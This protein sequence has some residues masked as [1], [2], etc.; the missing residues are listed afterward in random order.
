MYKVILSAFA[1]SL[2]MYG[3]TLVAQTQS[4]DDFLELESEIL[5]ELKGEQAFTTSDLHDS[6]DLK[7]LP[8]QALM[9]TP[10]PT[11]GQKYSLIHWSD[12]DPIEWMDIHTWV[13]ERQI[14]DKIPNWK[15]S[16]RLDAHKELA[17]KVLKCHGECLSYRGR[18]VTRV[19]HL[20]RLLEGD[21]IQTGT[22][23]VAWIF[24]M[25]GSLVR[26][27][28]HTSISIHEINITSNEFF[29]LIRLNHG[30]IYW[31]P[32]TKNEIPTEY[33]PETDAISLPILVRE[34]NQEHFE[35]LRRQTQSDSEQLLETMDLD[36]KAIDDQFAKISAFK[37]R[38]NEKLNLKSKVMV[39]ASNMTLI[40]DN[41]SFDILHTPGGKSFF[42]KRSSEE[43]HELALYLRGYSN[44]EK[45]PIPDLDWNE[46]DATGRVS[47][48]VENLPGILQIIELISKRIKTIE[49]AREH[50]VEE[51]TLPL[52]Q[53]IKNPEMLSKD[54][55]YHL[56]G[57]EHIKRLEF[58][59][60]Y[61]RRQ[62]T[63][64]LKA[65]DNLV[66]KFKKNG[67][68]VNLEISPRSYQESLNHYLLGLK[69][70][71]DNKKIQVRDMN[72]LQYYVWILKNGKF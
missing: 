12:L 2:M 60:E 23:S 69:S 43:G 68:L 52:V 72:D 56:W 7:V 47:N 70:R 24:M 27:S 4:V 16:L 3:A 63:S 13:A 51:F 44:L 18:G 48:Q 22:D 1:L 38:N 36:H 59:T 17:G 9:D 10:N 67:E 25:D 62:E 58:L 34:A 45:L 53:S 54:F 30:H 50:W 66:E 41:V 15:L 55:G 42:K 61:T 26:L 35:R 40:G 28:P 39:V 29:Y 21:E 6:P 32:R 33:G 5:P 64:H 46:V 65:L 20:S 31:H 19:Q 49:L 14:K 37:S 11:K 8:E 57:E 71:Y